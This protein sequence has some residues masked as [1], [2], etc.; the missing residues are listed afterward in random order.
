M[1]SSY[2]CS[3]EINSVVS[4]PLEKIE[5]IKNKYSDGKQDFLDGISV[6]YDN[7]RFNVL[8]S[9]TGPLLRLNV[10]SKSDHNLM[11]EKTSELLD[12]IRS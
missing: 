2:P 12:L 1:I 9:N 8:L 5:M 10:E 6:D 3:G 11:K 7:W 4:N